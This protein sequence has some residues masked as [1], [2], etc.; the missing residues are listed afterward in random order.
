MTAAPPPAAT[1]A[2]S[3]APPSSTLDLLRQRPPGLAGLI[4]RLSQRLTPTPPPQGPTRRSVVVGAALAGSAL[5]VDPVG[6][7]LRPQSAYATVCGPSAR[8]SDGWTVFCCTVNKGANSC[9]PGSFAAGWWKA[10]DSS[11]CCG[12]Y[13]YIVDCNATCSKCSCGSGHLC[14]KKCWSCS[15]RR[16]SSSSCDQRRHCCNA[17]RYGQCNTHIRCS[18]GVVCRVASCVPPYTFEA[19][20]RTSLRDDRTREHNAPCLQGCGPLLRTYLALGGQKSYLG[21]SLGPE[22]AVGD[23]SGRFVRYAGGAIYWSKATG[24]HALNAGALAAYLGA[25]GPRGPLG[26][27]LADSPAPSVTGSPART[28]WTQR[29]R[30]GSVVAGPRTDPQ[31]IWGDAYVVWKRLGF[32]AGILGHPSGPRAARRDKGW[33]QPFRNGV[34]IAGPRTK[35]AGV[36]RRVFLAWERAGG[37]D[38]RYGYPV[39]DTRQRAEGGWEG[40]FEGGTIRL[41]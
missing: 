28:E 1:P 37:A 25:G 40:V 20:T 31:A 15:C 10:A 38:G 19:C 39:S 13:R 26:Y 21:H 7:V 35:P 14:S 3:S 2:P 18:G 9:P 22:R 29:F 24:A 27:P 8:A 36:A 32:G 6:F 23:G 33:Q 34:V 11:W 4:G 12:G 16:G 5:A 30:G 17:F 41:P